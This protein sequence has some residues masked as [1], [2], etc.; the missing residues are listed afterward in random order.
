MLLFKILFFSCI[1]LQM[2]GWCLLHDWIVFQCVTHFHYPWLGV[3]PF[4]FLLLSILMGAAVTKAVRCLLNSDFISVRHYPVLGWLLYPIFCFQ[5]LHVVLQNDFIFLL[6]VYTFVRFMWFPLSPGSTALYF[7]FFTGT[8]RAE[9]HF[10]C[11]ISHKLESNQRKY[12]C[13]DL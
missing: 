7:I 13:L 9:K 3:E 11:F 5:K 1:M 6:Y 2:R 12:G 8:V 10:W 4:R